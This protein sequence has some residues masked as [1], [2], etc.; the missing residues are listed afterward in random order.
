[1]LSADGFATAWKRIPWSLYS[2][3]VLIKTH[4]RFIQWFYD[5]LIPNYHFVLVKNDLKDLI[6][7]L[8]WLTKNDNRSLEIIKNANA[9]AEKYLSP[10]AVQ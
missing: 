4:S 1:M 5:K 6:P 10:K 2:N 7:K 8:K 3:S 9:F